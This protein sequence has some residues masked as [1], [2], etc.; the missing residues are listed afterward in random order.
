VHDDEFVGPSAEA[1]RLCIATATFVEEHEGAEIDTQ[2]VGR[3]EAEDVVL[4]VTGVL[5][6]IGMRRA[7][8]P[9]SFEPMA[10]SSSPMN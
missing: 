10:M 8:R 4:A 3:I 1:R 5:G 2:G 6:T 9:S 7:K